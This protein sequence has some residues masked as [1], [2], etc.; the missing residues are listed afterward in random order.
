MPNEY[1]LSGFVLFSTYPN[2]DTY[3]IWIGFTLAGTH[4]YVKWPAQRTLK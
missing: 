1:F 2:F 3:L 4:E